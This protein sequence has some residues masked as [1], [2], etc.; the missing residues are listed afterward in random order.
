MRKPAAKT[1]P[2]AFACCGSPMEVSHTRN[3]AREAIRRYRRCAKCGRKV[4]TVE[5][6]VAW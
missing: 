1:E 4:V 3:L 2:F 5:R 6:P